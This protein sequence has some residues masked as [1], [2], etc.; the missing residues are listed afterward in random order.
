MGAYCIYRPLRM[1]SP[2]LVAENSMLRATLS[3]LSKTL[4]AVEIGISEARAEIAATTSISMEAEGAVVNSTA[5]SEGT[6]EPCASEIQVLGA[7]PQLG[8]LD[9]LGTIRPGQKNQIFLRYDMARH[10]L[11]P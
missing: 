5:R 7:V 8:P 2:S 4:C 3:R 9:L 10:T 1:A 11:F 6:A